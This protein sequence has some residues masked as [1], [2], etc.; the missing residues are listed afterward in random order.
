GALKVYGDGNQVPK[1]FPILMPAASPLSSVP[2]AKRSA[3]NPSALD[4][5]GSSPALHRSSSPAETVNAC[6]SVRNT[7][8]SAPAPPVLLFALAKTSIVTARAE[9]VPKPANPAMN[10]QI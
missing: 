1:S 3:V 6:P 10:A 2:V 4:Q 8:V 5:R 9:V 7:P